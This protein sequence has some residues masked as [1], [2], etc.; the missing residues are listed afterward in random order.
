MLCSVGQ[1]RAAEGSGPVYPRGLRR[2]LPGEETAGAAPGEG[3]EGVDTRVRE[4]RDKLELELLQQGEEHYECLLK[5]KE[6]HV[7]EVPGWGREGVTTQ[8]GSHPA[9]DKGLDAKLLR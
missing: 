1:T 5:R 9:H 6:Q 3:P 7:A 2:T 4:L 8:P